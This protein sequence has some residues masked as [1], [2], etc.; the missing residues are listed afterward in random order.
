MFE[1]NQGT[2]AIA[3]RPDLTQRT[4]HLHTKYWH[5]KDNL[6]VEA[7]GSGITIECISTKDQLADLLTK[8]LGP[9]LFI[10]LRDKLMGW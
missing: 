7:D 3:K 10:P 2:I 4:R 9:G 8:G 6:K 1:D 5:F